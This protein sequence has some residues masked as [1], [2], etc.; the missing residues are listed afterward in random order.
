LALGNRWTRHFITDLRD[1]N[2]RPPDVYPRASEMTPQ[3]FVAIQKLLDKGFAYVSEGNVFYHVAA[4]PHFGQVSGLPKEKWLPTANERGNSPDDPHK[5]DPLDFVLWQAQKPGEPSWQSPWG[6]GRPGWHIE[7]STMAQ[8]Y[9]GDVIDVHGGGGDLC[10]P[11]HECETAQSFGMT[12]NEVF[13]RFWM[14]TAMVRYQ[15]EKMS[16]SLGNLIWARD[17]L[18]DYSADTVRLLVNAHPYHETWEYN[19]AELGPANDLAGRLLHAATAFGGEGSPLAAEDSVAAFEA[20]LDDNLNTRAALA[21]LGHLADRIIA[22]AA[23]GQAVG[24]AQ[25]QLRKLGQVFGL[26]F[27]GDIEPRVRQ[28]WDA[29]YQRFL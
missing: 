14:H 12:G 21:V 18:K 20:A 25:A 22:G 6:P 8:T 11:H 10:F 3:M 2:V 19:A 7:C 27:D 4:D 15:G 24:A 28:G 9:L 26:R 29:H 13:A 23:Q 17:L 1:L 5:R 16:K